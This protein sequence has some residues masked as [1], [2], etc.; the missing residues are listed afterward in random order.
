[1]LVPDDGQVGPACGNRVQDA[2][3]QLP[4][5]K[6]GTEQV[7]DSGHLAGG[8]DDDPGDEI[9]VAAAGQDGAARVGQEFGPEQ[10]LIC[11]VALGTCPLPPAQ[12]AGAGARELPRRYAVKDSFAR[13][14]LA[15]E[16]LTLVFEAEWI[17]CRPRRRPGRATPACA[18]TRWAATAS[19]AV[20]SGHK[21]IA[22][23]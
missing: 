20:T 2:G 1:M 6:P 11:A 10:R 12:F 18:G 17:A 4:G 13:L 9:V 21:L 23:G 7:G 15:A 5:R 16:G 19:G 3:P 14:D 22:F 8:V